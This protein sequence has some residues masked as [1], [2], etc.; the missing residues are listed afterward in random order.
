M[1]AP[2]P[3]SS[4]DYRRMQRDQARWYWRSFR[5]QSIAGPLLLIGIGVVALLV[6]MG[7]L[8]AASVWVWY[9]HWWPLLLIG[10]GLI[11]LLEWKFDQGIPPRNHPCGGVLPLLLLLLLV[12]YGIEGVHN[13]HGF[14][15]PQGWNTRGNNPSAFFLPAFRPAARH[16]P[17]PEPTPS[18]RCVDPNSEPERK[19]GGEPLLR[20]PDSRASPRD[21]LYRQR[22]RGAAGVQRPDSAD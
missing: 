21:G 9:L 20:Q 22:L 15:N 6:E 19:P 13:F 8:S 3:Y 10:I 5:R 11:Y 18:F 4:Q 1:A 16:D 17:H 12:A 2:P 14:D 7:K